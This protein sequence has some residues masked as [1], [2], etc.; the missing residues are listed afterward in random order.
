MAY[1]KFINYNH[2]ISPL[3]LG[4][5]KVLFLFKIGYNHMVK[6]KQKH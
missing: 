1:Q 3:V 2:P 6:L 5:S 4:N